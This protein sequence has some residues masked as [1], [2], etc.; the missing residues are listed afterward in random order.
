MRDV[1]QVCGRENKSFT[2]AH[3]FFFLQLA[4]IHLLRLALLCSTTTVVIY[5]TVCGDAQAEGGGIQRPTACAQNSRAATLLIAAAILFTI[6]V[7]FVCTHL[8]L[9]CRNQLAV[10]GYNAQK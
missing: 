8:V 10:R 9:Y 3:A 6:Q 1:G 7:L 2:D 4:G 5:L